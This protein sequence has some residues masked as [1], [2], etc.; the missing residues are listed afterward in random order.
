M[1][2]RAWNMSREWVAF[3]VLSPSLHLYRARLTAASWPP[4]ISAERSVQLAGPS[5]V[6]PMRSAALFRRPLTSVP[7]LFQTE[8]AGA[9]TRALC[10]VLALPFVGIVGAYTAAMGRTMHPLGAA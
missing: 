5:V 10:I 4:D 2:T 8:K 6:E 1:G 9:V 7:R 3:S